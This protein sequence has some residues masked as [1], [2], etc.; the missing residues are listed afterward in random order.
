MDIDFW[1]S[2]YYEDDIKYRYEV[3]YHYHYNVWYHY[4]LLA[5]NDLFLG[6][7]FLTSRKCTKKS[8]LIDIIISAFAIPLS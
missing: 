6:T 2:A 7:R 4:I 3:Q 8:F 5:E 1:N